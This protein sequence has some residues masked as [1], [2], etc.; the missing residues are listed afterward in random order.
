MYNPTYNACGVKT[1]SY[2]AKK[3]MSNYFG[4]LYSTGKYNIHKIIFDIL[5]Y[6]FTLYIL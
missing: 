5:F 1:H 6:I 3:N 4:F 2:Q